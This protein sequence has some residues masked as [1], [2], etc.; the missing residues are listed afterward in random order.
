MDSL[1]GLLQL[2]SSVVLFRIFML[3]EADAGA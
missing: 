1:S 2:F 3:L